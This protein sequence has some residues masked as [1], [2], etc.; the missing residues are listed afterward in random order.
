MAIR[1]YELSKK[2]GLSNKELID[3]LQNLGVEVSSHISVLPSDIIDLIEEEVK[4]KVNSKNKKIEKEEQFVESQAIKSKPVEEQ[5]H[6]LD[7]LNK[8]DDNTD[9]KINESLLLE[10]LS[11]AQIAQKINKPINEII[12]TLLKNGI[13]VNKNQ[14]LTEKNIKKIADV[15]GLKISEKAE[16]KKIE[17][18][19]LSNI[20]KPLELEE[21]SNLVEREPIIVVIGH[22]DH[23]KTTLLDFIR[24]TKVAAKEKGGIT[25]HLGAYEVKIPQGN[26]VFLD[27][28]GHEAFSMLR[29][30]GLK[31]ADIAILVVAADDGVMPQTVEAINHA[32]SVGLPI[33]VAINK[34]DKASSK[35]IESVEQQLSQYG[36]IKEEWGGNTPIVYISAK[37]GAGVDELLEVVVLQSKLME[38]STNLNVPARG[39]ILESKVEKGRGAVATVISQNGII[40]IGDYFFAGNTYGKVNSLINSFGKKLN[41]AE[42]SIPVLVSGFNELPYAGDIFRVVS[43]QEYKN[44]PESSFKSE[45]KLVSK[46][47]YTE[48]GINIIVKADNASSKE[49]LLKSIEKLSSNIGQNFNVIYSGISDITESDAILALDT[50]SIIYAFHVKALPNALN[51]INKNKITVKYFDIIYN[52]LEDLESVAEA[53]KPINY[54]NKKVGQGTV[55]KVFDIKSLGKV[56]GVSVKSGKLIRDSKV[57]IFRSNQKIGEGTIKSLERERKSVKEVNTGFECALLTDNFVDWQLGDIIECYQEVP[58]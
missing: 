4:N 5:S 29:V 32:K 24:K 9:Q 51:F 42:P 16:N 18:N 10:S 31:A 30:R 44:K 25:Q 3:I 2:L 57:M 41:K 54:I 55:I 52:L 56:A 39:Y 53:L 43:S 17:Q 15:Y 26:M 7:K 22:V 45:S 35:Q 23:G 27:T 6:N 13:I 37:T 28:P 36:L 21:K 58:A 8:T 48:S 46:N 47:L 33:I 20:P 38:L 12:L 19:I 50:Q 11:V 14:I 1:V 34:I 49:A 40:K